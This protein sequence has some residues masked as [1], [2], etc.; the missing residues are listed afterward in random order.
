MD[1]G[2]YATGLLE[3]VQAHW[4]IGADHWISSEPVP[5]KA[6]SVSSS[7]RK[8][9]FEAK[10]SS[11]GWGKDSCWGTAYTIAIEGRLFLF[12]DNMRVIEV[13]PDDLFEH[14]IDK[15]ST[16]MEIIITGPSGP[17]RVY[18]HLREGLTRGVPWP[19]GPV[20]LFYPKPEPIPPAELDTLR[21]AVFPTADTPT[22]G[23]R[24]DKK[25]GPGTHSGDSPAGVPNDGNGLW[26]WTVVSLLILMVSM[27]FVVL[28]KL[29]QRRAQDKPVIR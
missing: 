12:W 4:L 25:S 5:V 8:M 29:R 28:R 1:F 24:P 17:R 18:F 27:V 19:I 20:S 15:D 14:R 2:V 11:Y 23:G 26:F 13:S 3:A 21:K 16:N 22:S 7:D 6:V 9:V 10:W